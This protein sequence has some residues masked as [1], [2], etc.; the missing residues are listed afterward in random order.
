MEAQRNESPADETNKPDGRRGV[1]GGQPSTRLVTFGRVPFLP[2]D[3]AN[4]NFRLGK[5]GGSF[6]RCHPDRRL[7]ND[8]ADGKSGCDQPL[9]RDS[10]RLNQACKKEVS[11][12]TFLFKRKVEKRFT[13]H[14][15]KAHRNESPADDTNKPD[16]W[17]GSGWANP[18]SSRSSGTAIYA[19][20]QRA[21]ASGMPP[22][23]AL[24]L[25][26]QIVF[27]YPHSAIPSRTPRFIINQTEFV[28]TLRVSFC[29][30]NANRSESSKTS[31][32]KKK[33][34]SKKPGRMT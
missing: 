11:F 33:P 20:G 1:R 12:A 25:A 10:A 31:D 19:P 22:R 17:R 8:L 23:P 14:N 27:T 9:K 30:V 24:P 6:G 4:E 5:E 13:P 28:L 18:L 29:N 34:T 26:C 21:E 32:P 3:S 2:R 16:G 7:S 15:S